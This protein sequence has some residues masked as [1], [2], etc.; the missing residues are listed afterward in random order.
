MAL[1]PIH[2]FPARMAPEIVSRSLENVP[3][4]GCVLDPM[5]GSGTVARA[6]V[7]AG[8]RFI[9]SDLD[10]L[11]VLMTKVWTTPIDVHCLRTMALE[12]IDQ[13]DS[14]PPQI[15]ERTRDPETLRFISYW[16]AKPQQDSLARLATVISR[17]EPKAKGALAIAMSRIIVSKEMMASLARD[18]SHS[19]PHKVAESNDFDVYSGFL[20]SAHQVSDRLAPNSIR[21]DAD[22]RLS[23]ARTLQSVDDETVDMVLTS[24][25]YLNALDYIRGHRLSL[26]WLGYEMAPLRKIRASSVGAERSI[27]TADTPY[28]ISPF[29]SEQVGASIGS[30]HLGWVRR[31]AA[32]MNSVLRQL[33]RVLK[34]HGRAVLIMGNSFLRGAKVDNAGLVEAIAE[35]VGFQVKEK[36][37]REIPARRRYLPPPG[38]GK[39]ALDARIRSETVLTFANS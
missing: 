30:R 32:D 4:G 6:S 15:V 2:P 1:I 14:M 21:A 17:L 36:H 26:V 20:R 27:D 8:Y 13:A 24:P 33:R 22:I 35:S 31:Y 28:D 9:G 19:R 11:A 25:P 23:D 29:V 5:C 38:I 7:E 37:V 16:F 12:V 39:K 3:R 10:P 34:P 18:T